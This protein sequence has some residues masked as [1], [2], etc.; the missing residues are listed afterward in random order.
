MAGNRRVI[1][2]LTGLVL[3]GSWLAAPSQG[4]MFGNR[5]TGQPLSSQ[6][7]AGTLSAGTLQGNE[8]FLRGNR[9]QSDF[10]GMGSADVGGFVG[11]V[12]AANPA[13][14]NIVLFQPPP[15]RRNLS[16]QINRPVRARRPNT[17]HEPVLIADFLPDPERTAE[18]EERAIGR[19]QSL[20]FDR[21]ENRIGVSVEGRTAT[22]LGV[23]NDEDDSR[24]AEWIVR[25]EPGISEIRNQI[26][27]QSPIPPSTNSPLPNFDE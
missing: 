13:S 21:F 3:A 6:V 2:F 7:G 24:L 10:V 22:L 4:Q 20:F 1:A 11:Q 27:V 14:G 23:A 9:S 19:L 26:Q 15:A 25:M 12:N 18:R 8:R 5:R 17:L 16:P